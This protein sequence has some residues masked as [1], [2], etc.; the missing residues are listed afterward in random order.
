MVAASRGISLKEE[1]IALCEAGK[2][3]RLTTVKEASKEKSVVAFRGICRE[4]EGKG[5]KGG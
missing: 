1:G 2:T 3:K 4:E 5:Y